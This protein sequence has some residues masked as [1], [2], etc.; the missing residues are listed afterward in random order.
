MFGTEVYDIYDTLK[1]IK[2][3]KQCHV[4]YLVIHLAILLERV[5]AFLSRLPRVGNPPPLLNQHLL[6][7]GG[8]TT[9]C[10]GDSGGFGYGLMRP[11]RPELLQE[12]VGVPSGA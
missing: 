11:R 9:A 5:A 8:D 1:Y 3:W 4:T 2:V 6:L 12:L 10:T 7:F